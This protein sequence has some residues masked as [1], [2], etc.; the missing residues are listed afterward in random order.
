MQPL[1]PNHSNSSQTARRKN[2]VGPGLQKFLGDKN[3]VGPGHQIFQGLESRGAAH[4]QVILQLEQQQQQHQGNN[5]A[6]TPTMVPPP[7]TAGDVFQT[8]LSVV[9]KTLEISQGTGA[10]LNSAVYHAI[11]SA[12]LTVNAQGGRFTATRFKQEED[13]LFR[14]EVK[15]TEAN[16]CTIFTLTA[17]KVV[18]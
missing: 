16:V 17:T 1:C 15:D 8:I 14:I 9:A 4:N 6:T 2:L 11:V 13:G 12:A 5:K 18:Q 10:P 3:L 7:A